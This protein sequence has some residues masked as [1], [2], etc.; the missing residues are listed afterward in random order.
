MQI[1]STSCMPARLVEQGSARDV[2]AD[3][4]HPYTVGLL[5]SVPRLDEPRKASSTPL[6]GNRPIS[7]ICRQGVPLPPAVSM[8]SPAV[9]L[10]RR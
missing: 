6:T 7:R 2:Y 8:P 1:G 9:R 10:A 3:P 4:R 5:R